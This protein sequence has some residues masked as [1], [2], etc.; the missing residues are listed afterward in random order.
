MRDNKISAPRIELLHPLIRKQTA[1]LIE[2][3]ET[4]IATNSAIRVVQGYRTFAEQ[5]ALYAQGRNGDTR[6]VVTYSRGGESYHNYG[7]AIDFA[8]LTDKDG[9]GSYEDLSWDIKRD[10]N[11][12]GV[13][14]WI[15]VV[16][17]FE[18]AGWKW[19]GKWSTFKDYPH[20]E[21]TYDL[22]VKQLFAKYSS[23]DFIPQT[24]YVNL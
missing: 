22:T 8:I 7:L 15:Q 12:D 4:V 16:N 17:A 20:L 24:T 13:A 23:K 5:N 18:A 19:G 9:N 3:V 6:S 10:N 2:N 21:K 11:K 14:D 1:R